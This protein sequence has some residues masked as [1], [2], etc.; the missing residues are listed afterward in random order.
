MSGP[1]Q[2]VALVKIPLNG[3]RQVHASTAVPGFELWYD[4]QNGIWLHR[5]VKRPEPPW[6]RVL[7]GLLA[8]LRAIARH[9]PAS[10]RW[11]SPLAWFLSGCALSVTALS[12][13]QLLAWRGSTEAEA[14]LIHSMHRPSESSRAVAPIQSPPPIY[15]GPQKLE[16]SP[17]QSRSIE[18]RGEAFAT[19]QD[20]VGAPRLPVKAP[21]AID[22]AKVTAPTPR[23]QKADAKLS[24][25]PKQ[26]VAVQATV[27][28]SMQPA[29]A[30]QTERENWVVESDP[31]AAGHSTHLLPTVQADGTRPKG[32]PVDSPVAA[33]GRSVEASRPSAAIKL[34]AISSRDEAV[35]TT[36]I[37]NALPVRVR[38]GQKLPNGETLFSID[39]HA[40]CLVTASDKRLCIE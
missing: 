14:A 19:S 25:Q 12:A 4:A 22:V 2:S 38:V 20:L 17:G 18:Y 29:A 35:V 26:Q 8:F 7:G 13:V 31:R 24:V 5:A 34:A 15:V 30:G 39:V 3:M 27:V 23:P 40:Q 6:T 1:Q 28:A 10:L 36:G 11:R 16:G 21:D 37:R 9:W 33:A 32:A